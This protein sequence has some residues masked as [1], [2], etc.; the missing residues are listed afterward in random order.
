MHTDLSINVLAILAMHSAFAF[1]APP[2]QAQSRCG[3]GVG[4]CDNSCC[5]QYGYCGTSDEYCGGSQCQVEYSHSCHTLTPPGR[6]TSYIP[7][8]HIGNVPYGPMLTSCTKPGLVA[9]TFD[10]GPYIYTNELLD[11]LGEYNAK[12]TFFVNGNNYAKPR[13]DD[14]ATQWP[15]TLMRMH[16]EGHHIGS[17]TW[18]HVDLNTASDTVRHNEVIY[19]E[20]ALRNIF[21]WI[22]TYLRPPF[23]ECD[24][25]KT[26]DGTESCQDFL[27]REGYHAISVNLDSKDYENDDPALIQ[28]SKDRISSGLSEDAAHNS[29]IILFHDVHEQTV[30][31]LARFVLDLVKERG[32][33]PV[34]VG[35]CLGDPKN[36]W[37]RPA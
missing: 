13:I 6:D 24:D 33:K 14:P 27:A 29:Y 23:L 32:Y 1:A 15:T 12:A 21:G 10:D 11:L 37:Y 35:E 5:S 26:G 28:I 30:H 19:N 9:I 16:G 25:T 31:S 17:H 3:P 22:P 4:S 18:T 7:R 2:I 8:P 20:M 36:N 34:T